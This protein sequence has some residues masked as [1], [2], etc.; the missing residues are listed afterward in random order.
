MID[1]GV[2]KARVTSAVFNVFGNAFGGAL[3]FS[4]C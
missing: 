3:S 2:N 1:I 4:P